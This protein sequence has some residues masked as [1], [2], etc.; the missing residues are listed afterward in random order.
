MS[1]KKLKTIKEKIFDL[2]SL[3]KALGIDNASARVSASRLLKQG[4]I[5]RIK[6]GIYILTEN[7]DNITYK[8]ILSIANIIQ[9]PSYIS[10]MSALA[11]YQITT[12]IQ[13]DFIES[14]S[15][16][17]TCEFNVGD[18][19]YNFTRIDADLF[20]GFIK[21]D[22]VFIA[23]PEK[24][25]LDAMYLRSLGRYNFDVSSLDLG[26]L[27]QKLA[28]KYSKNYPLRTQRS[29]KAICQF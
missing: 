27:N 5:K 1:Y 14:I 20:F 25:F 23:K 6:R 13:P 17:R 29:I 21:N 16:K 19:T 11:Y 2:N 9:V 22:E 12:Q 24:A 26:K 3:S 28:G 15:Q 8:G 7:L 10:L 4:L 18:K